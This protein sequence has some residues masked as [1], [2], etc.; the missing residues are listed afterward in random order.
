M[1]RFI[2]AGLSALV[3]SVSLLLASCGDSGGG[4][5][6]TAG[7]STPTPVATATATVTATR[8]AGV[9][10]ESAVDV[11]KQLSPSVV[12]ILSEAATLD[13]FGQVTPSKG[14]GTGFVLDQKGHIVTNNHVVTID[15]GQP[16][17]KITVTLSDGRQF[18]ARIVGRDAPTDLAVL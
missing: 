18:Q 15:S 13:V 17:Q 7:P 1:P 14:V 8:Q 4:A 5:T 10:G 6:P 16:A 9:A 12:H 11:V 2:L 3:L